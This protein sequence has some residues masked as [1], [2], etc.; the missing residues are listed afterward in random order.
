MNLLEIDYICINCNTLINHRENTRLVWTVICL[1]RNTILN[2][3]LIS[4]NEVIIK[5]IIE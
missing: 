2:I 3:P 4:C 5:N 1:K